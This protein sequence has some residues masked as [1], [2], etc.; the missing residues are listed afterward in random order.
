MLK[1]PVDITAFASLSALG[2]QHEEIRGR[3]LSPEHC[4]RYEEGYWA[5][6][7]PLDLGEKLESIQKEK[8][9]YRKVDKTVL[10]GLLAGRLLQEKFPLDASLSTG[11]N[12]GSSRGATQLWEQHHR[13][14]MMDKSLSPS[15][16]PSTT[17][18]NISSW[19]ADDLRVQGPALSHSITCS[20]ALHAVLNGIAWLQ[21]GMAD[22]FLVGGSEAPL[23][24]FTMAQME[25]LRLVSPG[26]DKESEQFPCRSMDL[27]KTENHLVLGEGAGMLRLEIA[28]R[29]PLAR[30]VGVGYATEPLESA[31]GLST[32]AQ[33]FQQSMKQALGSLPPD[34]V[35]AVVM[36]A[37]G[38]LKGD[39]SEYQAIEKVFCNKIPFLTT[40][41]WKIG[42][43]F[44]ASGIFSLLQALF[45]LENDSLLPLPFPVQQSQNSKGPMDYVL[46]NAVGFGGNAV[47]ILLSK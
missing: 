36:H 38:T 21:S 45:M 8:K 46:V 25:A 4:L 43:T 34:E 13:D 10:M 14:Y 1:Q 47:S 24:P 12:M 41:K 23:T 15:T 20:T 39:A 35:D 27:S 37:P 30:I 29:N 5:G 26:I 22:A 28:S 7:L 2:H 11:I 17:L 16:S 3:L 9:V 19:L 44:G 42:H 33:C 31:A 40:H 18:G 32:E 6:R